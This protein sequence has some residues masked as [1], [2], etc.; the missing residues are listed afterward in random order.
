MRLRSGFS[1]VELMITLTVLSIVVIAVSVVMIGSQR[2]KASTEANVEAQQSGRSVLEIMTR[3]IRSAGFQTD[4]DA[5]P[6][7]P[8]FAY[9]DSTELILFANLQPAT[10]G[11]SDDPDPTLPPLAPDPNGTPIPN[12][13][14]G[15]YALPG[16]YLTGAEM[17][18]YTFDINND[19][20]ITASD[21]THVAAT[22]ARRSANPD[23]Y[24]LARMVYGDSSGSV[25]TAGNNGGEVEK[26][27]LL[28][29][30][31]PG[32]PHLFTVFLGSDPLPWDWANGPVPANRLDEISRVEINVTTESRRPDRSGNYARS[33]I[34]TEVNSIRNVP[35][36]G[37]SYYVADGHVFDDVDEDG[38]QDS[39]EPGIPNVVVRMGTVALDRTNS[40][41]YYFLKVAPGQYT[42]RQEVPIGYGAFT[43]D[44]VDVDFITSPVDITHDFADTSKRGGWIIDTSWVDVN[45]NDVRETDEPFMD[46]VEIS[47]AGQTDLS[48]LRGHTKFFAPP[49]IWNVEAV[50]PESMVV[51][52]TNPVGVTVNDGDTLHVDFGVNYKGT[53]TVSGI[54]YKDLNV[55]YVF[56]SGEPGVPNVWVGVVVAGGGPTLAWDVSNSKGEY[57]LEVPANMPEAVDAYAITIQVPAGHYPT[58]TTVIQ[59]LWVETG[60]TYPGNNFG[61]DPFQVITLNAER[62]LSLSSEELKEKDWAG[63]ETIDKY[64]SAGKHDV[65]LILG[66]EWSAVPNI[67]VW[68][69]QWNSTPLFNPDPSYQRNAWASALDVG[70]RDLDIGDPWLQADMVAGLTSNASGNIA[71]WINQSTS[72][73]HGYFTDSPTFYQTLDGGDA[74]AIL[75][76]DMADGDIDIIVGTK[77][78]AGS[79]SFEVWTNNG[80]S[81]PVFGRKGTYPPDGGVSYLGE[82]HDMAFGDFDGD[83]QNNDLVLVTRTGPLTGSIMFFQQTTS[84]PWYTYREELDLQGEGRAVAVLDVDGDG[85]DDVVVGTKSGAS[86]G[87]LLVYERT[88]PLYPYDM[89]LSEQ[90]VAPGI[91]LSLEATELGGLVSREDLAVGYRNSESGFSGGVDVF[92]LDGGSLPSQGTDPSGGLANFMVPALNGNNFDSGDNPAPKV[93]QLDDLAGAMKSSATTGAVLVFLR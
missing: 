83:A 60:E 13:V 5:I 7:Q 49:G 27:G 4:V 64:N 52:T 91:V 33:T 77:T 45:K 50:A 3:D 39:G 43:P 61:I 85:Y 9:V 17:I 73:N 10:P 38:T 66:S 40:T 29:G 22:S 34:T 80:A 23:D 71:V 32:V 41:G 75:L 26:V 92:F 89:R 69:N 62:V 20:Q 57:L 44:S 56:D 93:V 79:G 90:H 30:P 59:P 6:P 46:N 28:R 15:S 88:D 36:A 24:V 2:S 81:P 76:E 51:T 48:D 21:Q 16:K 78:Y 37:F 74:N 14:A 65:D 70:V 55:N 19:G 72:G 11:D 35:D 82:V 31:G 54:V 42:L 1:L 53:G 12:K 86:Q 63:P 25:P 18:R 58:T 87:K 68:F 8:A 47:V 67:S 84:A